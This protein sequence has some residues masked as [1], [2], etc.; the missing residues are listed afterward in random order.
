MKRSK[1]NELL[2]IHTDL[3]RSM[4]EFETISTLTKSQKLIPLFLLKFGSVMSEQLF[5]VVSIVCFV[6]I[7]QFV[8]NHYCV[9][10]NSLMSLFDKNI[11]HILNKDNK[12]CLAGSYYYANL[13]A[14]NGAKI[15]P[16]GLSRPVETITLN[17][18]LTVL[19]QPYLSITQTHVFTTGR[20]WQLW[21][22]TVTFLIR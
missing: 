10:L 4:T 14:S 6:Q 8:L 9:A 18:C 15:A 17:P 2:L 1:R 12:T 13:S 20:S 11:A 19:C 3:I 5:T 7:L 21:Y 22:T 16:F